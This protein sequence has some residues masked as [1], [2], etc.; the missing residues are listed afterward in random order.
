MLYCCEG[1]DVP[2]SRMLATYAFSIARP[3][4]DVRMLLRASIRSV[5]GFTV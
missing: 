1:I 5:L 3:I 4:R 2:Y